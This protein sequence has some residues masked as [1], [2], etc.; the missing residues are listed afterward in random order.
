[1]ITLITSS[2]WRNRRALF[3]IC[4]LVFCYGVLRPEP[5]PDLFPDSDKALH[6]LA[7]G[8]LSFSARLAFDRA[9]AWLLWPMLVLSAPASEWLQHVV[10]PAREFSVGDI[11]ANLVGVAL[12][13]LVWLTF[14]RLLVPHQA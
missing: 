14:R 1:M 13:C 4:L 11:Q 10:Q 5:P 7:F 9:P 8:G 2:I 6:L 12:G 3:I